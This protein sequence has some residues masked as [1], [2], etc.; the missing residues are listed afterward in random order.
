MACQ[1]LINYKLDVRIN[2]LFLQF[3]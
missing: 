2:H 3:Y 1:S